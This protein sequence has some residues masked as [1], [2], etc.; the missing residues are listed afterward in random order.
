MEDNRA[1][2]KEAL[3]VLKEFNGRVLKN[4]N[5]VVKE[6]SGKRLDDTNQFLRGIIDAIN[7]EVEVVNGTMELLNEDK[8]RIK[9]EQFNAKI[10][11]FSDAIAA[12]DDQKMADAVQALI[13]EFENLGKA[14]EEVTA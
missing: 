5:I 9:K 1:E 14:A 10:V 12:K 6:L 11:A 3:E 7:W 8:E 13:P 2:Q 4:M